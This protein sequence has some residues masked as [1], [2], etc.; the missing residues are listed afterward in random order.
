MDA[1]IYSQKILFSNSYN[2]GASHSQ[3]VKKVVSDSIDSWVSFGSVIV[4]KLLE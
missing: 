3:E 4:E 2:D 1:G